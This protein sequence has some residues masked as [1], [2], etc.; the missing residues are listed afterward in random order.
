[1]KQLNL[2]SLFLAFCLFISMNIVA[3]HKSMTI[4][5]QAPG[6]LSSKIGYVD[7][8]SLEELK[9]S[10]Y[11]NGTDINFLVQLQNDQK[12]RVLDLSDVNIVK[13]GDKVFLASYFRYNGSGAY[14]SGTDEVQIKKDNHLYNYLFLPFKNLHKLSTPKAI[15]STDENIYINADTVI[16]NGSFK[17]IN[18]WLKYTHLP[19]YV[20]P[21]KPS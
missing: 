17:T 20:N 9:V 13:G 16:L 18:L 4:D 15:E 2:K 10:G 12:L 7:Q 6:W 14:Y 5:N 1:M 21:N 11:I 8:Q 19:N 3:Q